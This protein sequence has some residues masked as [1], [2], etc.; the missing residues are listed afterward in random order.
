MHCQHCCHSCYKFHAIFNFITRHRLKAKRVNSGFAIYTLPPSD[1]CSFSSVAYPITAAYSGDGRLLPAELF[2][3]CIGIGCRRYGAKSQWLHSSRHAERGE[4]PQF[5]LRQPPFEAGSGS[6]CLFV[7][8]N[9][10]MPCWRTTLRLQADDAGIYYGTIRYPFRAAETTVTTG[11]RER[12]SK[13]H[14]DQLEKLEQFSGLRRFRCG[15]PRVYVMLFINI[16]L[17]SHLRLY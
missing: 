12:D 8:S 16:L 1:R 10:R 15:F 11:R 14:T 13:F 3:W 6:D 2:Q 9:E 7:A 17:F 4:K 5:L